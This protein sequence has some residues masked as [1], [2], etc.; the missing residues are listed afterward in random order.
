[1]VKPAKSLPRA[2]NRIYDVAVQTELLVPTCDFGGTV[3]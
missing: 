2:P 1:M 3:A